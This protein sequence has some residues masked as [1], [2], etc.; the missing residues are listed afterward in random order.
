MSAAEFL[1]VSRTATQDSRPTRRRDCPILVHGIRPTDQR[2]RQ[3]FSCL[4]GR[5]DHLRRKAR[6]TLL[7]F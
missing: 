3:T 6:S 4:P 5:L 2:N 7:W 1:R